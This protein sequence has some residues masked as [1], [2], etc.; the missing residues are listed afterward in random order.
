MKKTNK[1]RL[2]AQQKKKSLG[3]SD[4]LAEVAAA[5]QAK[6]PQDADRALIAILALT[7]R[8]VDALRLLGI[9]QHQQ[10][11]FTAAVKVLRDAL[12][13]RPDDPLVLNNLGSSL[14]AAGDLQG[15]LVAFRRATEL[16]PNFAAAWFNLGKTLKMHSY[17]QEA[18]HAFERAVE[19]DSGYLRANSLLGEIMKGLGDITG[20]ANQFRAVL[21]DRSEAPHAWFKLANLKTISL[22]ADDVQQLQALLK[23]VSLSVD[24]KVHVGFALAKALEDQRDYD[25]AFNVLSEANRLKRSTLSWDA[26]S[27]STRIHA[28]E[29]AFAIPLS[30]DS[31]S[32][33]GSEVI[34]IT[35]L[36]RSGS[37]LT[38]QILAAHPQVTGA[39]ELHDLGHVLRDESKRRGRPFPEWTADAEREDWLRMGRDY[40]E[41][42]ARWREER[43]RFTDKGLTNWQYVGAAAAMLPGARFVNCRRDALETCLGGFR[44][45]FARGN[46]YTYDLSEL[47]AHWRGYDRLSKNWK[48]LHPS[49][50]FEQI[51]EDLLADPSAQIHR[52]LDFLDLPFDAEC[53]Q[54]HRSKRHV[55]TASAAQV[56]QPIRKDTARAALY[57]NALDPLRA[58]LYE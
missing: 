32:N 6:R 23:D 33:F 9:S 3:A 25:T 39:N 30:T 28:I 52:L 7:P 55:R 1:L 53:L 40:L 24:E 26:Q 34:F 38:E 11:N 22:S 8:N 31:P 19:C 54:F 47:G 17:P 16:K 35:S 14:R 20:A 46:E 50:V 21:H 10:S 45:L 12:E 43:P 49:R 58:A 18:Q 57:G 37:T 51:Y 13:I 42:T 41:R 48:Q 15:S 36:P 44:Q 56:R 4:L 5:L 2:A 29:S 27:Y